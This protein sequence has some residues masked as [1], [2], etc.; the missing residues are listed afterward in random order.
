MLNEKIFKTS[1]VNFVKQ[2]WY[3]TCLDAK[4]QRMMY[5]VEVFSGVFRSSSLLEAQVISKS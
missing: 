4:K 3:F 2:E 1:I 5:A